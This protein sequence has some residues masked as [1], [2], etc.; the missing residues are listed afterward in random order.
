MKTIE[1]WFNDLEEPYKTQAL[2]NSKKTNLTCVCKSMRESISCAFLWDESREGRE[3][4]F[5]LFKKY[6]K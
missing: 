5:N 2:E 3:Y 1:E 4:W 6:S